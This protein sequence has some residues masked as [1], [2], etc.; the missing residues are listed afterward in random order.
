M[1]NITDKLD[2]KVDVAGIELPACALPRDVSQGRTDMSF[3]KIISAPNCDTTVTVG[4]LI[5]SYV[6]FKKHIDRELEV[7]VTMGELINK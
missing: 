3:I 7:L 6:A 1:S 2:R 4:E 5:S